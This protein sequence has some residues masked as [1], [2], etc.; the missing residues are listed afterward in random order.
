MCLRSLGYSRLQQARSG[1]SKS[2]KQNKDKKSQK[3]EKKREKPGV[4]AGPVEVVQQ[5]VLGA[6]GLEVSLRLRAGECDVCMLRV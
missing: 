1:S 6:Y 5:E 2:Q 4:K 3:R